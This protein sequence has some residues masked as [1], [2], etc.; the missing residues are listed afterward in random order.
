MHRIIQENIDRFKL[1]LKIETEPTKRAMMIRLLVDE[2]AKQVLKLEK[3]GS[4]GIWL[5]V[6]A[7][8]TPMRRLDVD[9][10]FFDIEPFSAPF[11]RHGN[12]RAWIPCLSITQTSR[13][14]SDGAM[15]T[16]NH[17][18]G[19]KDRSYNYTSS[20]NNECP[21]WC[22][23]ILI[24]RRHCL[25]SSELAADIRS[26]NRYLDVALQT[27]GTAKSYS[28]VFVYFFSLLFEVLR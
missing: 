8:F 9:A 10:L 16:G 14:V 23:S 18:S 1:L 19:S 17:L 20:D 25:G 4:S 2:E 27:N 13:S 6:F 15:E 28:P 7:P 5:A 22:I 21:H 3:I 26:L 11:L 24:A 12:T